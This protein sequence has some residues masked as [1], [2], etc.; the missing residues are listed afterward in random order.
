MKTTPKKI[1]STLDTPKKA[2]IIG[3][4]V[5][6]SAGTPSK[7]RRTAIKGVKEEPDSRYGL[8]KIVSLFWTTADSDS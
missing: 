7:K 1:K 2:K 4:R 6:K 8:D 3:G 5:N